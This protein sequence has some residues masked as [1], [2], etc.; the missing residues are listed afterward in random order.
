MH[1]SPHSGVHQKN[2]SNSKIVKKK[3]SC[4]ATIEKWYKIIFLLIWWHN[5]C[6]KN[7]KYTSKMT[8]WWS[9]FQTS[10]RCDVFWNLRSVQASW[11][12]SCMT[13][14]QGKCV[15][16]LFCHWGNDSIF[17]ISSSYPTT[18]LRSTFLNLSK[19]VRHRLRV[20]SKKSAH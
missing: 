6:V 18:S 3:F 12:E 13:Q 7:L 8:P 17:G 11:L 14:I 19:T 16:I 5:V 1:K 15:I 9:I 2:I 4:T 10:Y 20:E